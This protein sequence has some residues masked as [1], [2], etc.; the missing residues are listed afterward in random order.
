MLE[1]QQIVKWLR[2]NRLLTLANY[3]AYRINLLKTYKSNREFRNRMPDFPF[4]PADISY[5]A[6]FTTSFSAYYTTGLKAA[7]SIY[8]ILKPYLKNGDN[9][10]CEWGC[11]AARIIRHMPMI[12]RR[13]N[14]SFTGTDYN[15]KTIRWCQKNILGIKFFLNNLAPPLSLADNSIDC[16][17][18][19]SVF[20]HLSEEMHFA[21]LDEIMRVLKPD[22][23]FMMTV[24]GDRS[25]T[26]LREEERELYDS[27]KFVVRDNVREGTRIFAA[28]H[29]PSFMRNTFLKG[30]EIV[31]HDTNPN[32][33]IASGQD[34]WIVRKP[35]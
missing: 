10:V 19:V 27:G 1:K 7:R 35:K 29:N 17:Y 5:D 12:A 22:G 16:A 28:F 13:Q 15:R 32:M 8:R 9:T 23:I 11:G 31:M 20:T 30:L 24:H 3:F 34:I 6:Y 2:D 25:R 21:W 18:G 4:P 14:V 33:Y 26:I